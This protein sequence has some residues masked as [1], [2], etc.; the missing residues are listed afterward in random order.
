ML[1]ESTGTRTSTSC[2]Q[3][4]TIAGILVD[5]LNALLRVCS[6]S[7]R[8]C[9]RIVLCNVSLSRWKKDFSSL[10]KHPRR[11]VIFV[12]SKMPSLGKHIFLLLKFS[13]L[14]LYHFTR[15]L[16]SAVIYFHLTPL[17]PSSFPL[18]ISP[19]RL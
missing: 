1:C 15:K 13:Y 7:L 17:R 14:S 6:L 5:H 2:S 11:V 18:R 8:H 16:L 19:K 10:I 3:T 9:T 4:E 12:L